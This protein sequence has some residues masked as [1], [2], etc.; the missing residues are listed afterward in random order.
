MNLCRTRVSFSLLSV[1]FHV[2]VNYHYACLYACLPVRNARFCHDNTTYC[3]LYLVKHIELSL[4]WGGVL[5]KYYC[6]ITEGEGDVLVNVL[7]T[8]LSDMYIRVLGERNIISSI[9]ERQNMFYKRICTEATGKWK[10]SAHVCVC[11]CARV[12]YLLP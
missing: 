11:V 8:N 5:C 1:F 12:L 6:Y 9:K 2:P 3:S 4:V 10:R 7:C